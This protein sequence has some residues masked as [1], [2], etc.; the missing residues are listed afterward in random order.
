MDTELNPDRPVLHVVVIGFHHKK[1]CQ[2]SNL[3]LIKTYSTL[4]C[5]RIK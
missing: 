4:F 2:V 3:N 1:G 5:Y